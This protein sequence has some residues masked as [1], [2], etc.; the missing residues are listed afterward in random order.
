VSYGP[1][2]VTPFRTPWT[3]WAGR[4]GKEKRQG[5]AARRSGSSVET[6]AANDVNDAA[7]GRE[8]HHVRGEEST[9]GAEGAKDTFEITRWPERGESG[10]ETGECWC[11]CAVRCAAPLKQ[12]KPP[13]FLST[14]GGGRRQ[15]QQST[16]NPGLTLI[17]AAPR[18]QV[19]R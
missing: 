19:R 15:R 17:K 10:K 13:S 4:S 8:A 11:D 12:T 6:G 2:A 3:R 18:P 9:R 5:E 14:G 16:R 1:H 7:Q